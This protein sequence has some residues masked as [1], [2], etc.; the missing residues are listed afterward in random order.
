MKIANDIRWYGSGPRAGFN[1]L[2]LPA[3][4]PGIKLYIFFGRFF[5]V[6]FVCAIYRGDQ[7]ARHAVL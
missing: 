5:L 1:E 4:E 2:K 7:N 6:F 3:N